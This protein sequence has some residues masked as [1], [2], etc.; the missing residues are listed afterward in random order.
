MESLTPTLSLGDV[1]FDLTKGF[2]RIPHKL[3]WKEKLAKILGALVTRPPVHL[4]MVVGQMLAC[5]LSGIYAASQL[6]AAGSPR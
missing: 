2:P 3:T 6:V 5:A 1:H 4:L